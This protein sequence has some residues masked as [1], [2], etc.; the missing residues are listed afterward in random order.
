MTDVNTKTKS[1][2]KFIV[3]LGILALAAALC[4]FAARAVFPKKYSAYVERE[5]ERYGLDKSE[6]YAV[7][8]A[9]SGFYPQAESSAGA[10]GL[11][12]LMPSTAEFCAQVLGVTEYDLFEPETNIR[13][14]CFYLD[15][16]KARF[17]GDS[18]YA[19]Y[20]AG[21]GNVRLWLESGQGIAFPET[22]TY[23]SRVNLY[24]RIYK[25]LYK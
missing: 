4:F 1:Q 19:A 11:M 21:E 16:L 10:K 3:A 14:G 2:N 24:R 20:N 6:V 25:F 8:M 5:A 15:Y 12:Q 18:V 13:F 23:V 17:S 9:E 22:R 7:I